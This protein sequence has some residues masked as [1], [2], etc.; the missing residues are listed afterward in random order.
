MSL[1]HDQS[2]S[3]NRHRAYYL[4]AVSFSMSVVQA[5]TMP[6]IPYMAYKLGAS[7]FIIGMIGS[8]G[9]LLYCIGT[10]A[11]GILSAIVVPY[12]IFLLSLMLYTVTALGYALLVRD[13]IDILLLKIIEGLSW[14]FLWPPLE[15]TLADV[16]SSH[17]RLVSIFSFSWSSGMILGSI[18]S[19]WSLRCKFSTVFFLSSSISFLCL[20]YGLLVRFDTNISKALRYSINDVKDV[21]FSDITWLYPLFYSLPLGI[22]FTFFPS[23]A[24]I[25][26]FNESIIASAIFVI[27]SSR[28]LVF[29]L[30]EKYVT[31]RALSMFLG[32][33]LASTGLLIYGLVHASA[34]T[35]ITASLLIGFGTGLIYASLFHSAITS[36]DR[37]RSIHTSLFEFSIGLGYFIGPLIG[38]MVAELHLSLPYVIGALMQLIGLVPLLLR[39]KALAVVS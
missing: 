23:H 25:W 34:H 19:N 35:I 27:I 31:K 4:F 3:L 32:S 8:I 13:P 39:S 22:I 33:L 7:Q 6:V 26:G 11:S 38:G 28:T 12:R 9:S 1:K 20:I 29:T 17:E 15:S 36:S 16:Y 5:V 14:S 30:A 21:M 18:L 37:L 10:L 2:R 24:P